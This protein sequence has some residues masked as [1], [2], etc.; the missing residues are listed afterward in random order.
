MYELLQIFIKTSQLLEENT[1]T[2]RSDLA[3]FEAHAQIQ[4]HSVQELYDQAQ[5]FM[6]SQSFVHPESAAGACSPA[7]F[8]HLDYNL[9]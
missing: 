4:R 5:V 8:S 2:I 3:G 9:L 6:E 1:S 7:S